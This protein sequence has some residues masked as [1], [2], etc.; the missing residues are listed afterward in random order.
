MSF[1]FHDPAGLFTAQNWTHFVPTPSMTV[2][3]ALNAVFRFTI[4]FSILLFAATGNSSY[5]S[6]IPLMAVV[7]IVLQRI[8]PETQTIRETYVSGP[9]VTGYRG[10]KRSRP[11]V[12][13]PF[14]NPKLTDIQ[15]APNRPPADDVTRADVADQVNR[16]FAQTS[17]LYMDTTDAYD[18]V[19]S[20]R[21]FYTV[22]D[23]NHEGLLRFLA[24]GGTANDKTL[25]ETY[26]PVKG[27][28][29]ELAPASTEAPPQGTA[30]GRTPF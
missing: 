3:E 27:T 11:E 21:N 22:A 24:K 12:D 4:Y 16:T 20:Q 30:P 15:D 17:N 7:T 28:V 8:F 19:Q 5:L 29:D 18:L 13:N 14:M 6:S 25:N 23:D 1:W 9:I 10:E 26:V 2:P